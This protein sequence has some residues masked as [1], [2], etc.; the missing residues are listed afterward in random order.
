MLSHEENS[1][2]RLLEILHLWEEHVT[3]SYCFSTWMPG[4]KKRGAPSPVQECRQPADFWQTL[5]LCAT[6]FGGCL[7]SQQGIQL[8]GP[9]I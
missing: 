1:P 6:T 4:E 9:V 2:P 8:S 3:E 5:T 7:A